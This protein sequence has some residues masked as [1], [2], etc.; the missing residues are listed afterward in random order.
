MKFNIEKEL[1][2]ELNLKVGQVQRTVD[3][4]DEGN[5]IPFIARYR[6][7]VTGSL[8]EEQL[9]ELVERLDYL[10]RLEGRKEEVINSIDK[11]DKL[12]EELEIKIRQATQLQEVEDL[13]RPYKQKR[14]T[15]ATKAKERG[16][17]PLA[18][19][20]LKQELTSGNVQ[21]LA[22][23]YVD[24]EKELESIEDVL[25]GVR[26][27]IAEYIADDPYSRKTAR[28]LT[29]EY[30]SLVSESKVEERTDY[31]IY[32]DYQEGI[33]KVRPHSTLAINRGEKEDV[34]RVKVATA[35]ENI[36]DKL[37][38]NF[39]LQE[40]IFTEEIEEAIIDGYNR[41]IAPAIEREVRN[42]LTELAEEHAI[43]V[44]AKNL[45]NLLLQPP[46]SKVRVMAIDPGFRTGS[47][48]SVLDEFGNFISYDTIYPHPPQKRWDE[49]KEKLNAL[50]K[51]YNIDIIAIGNGTASRETESLVVELIGELSQELKYIIVNEAGASVYSASKL[52]VKEFPHLDVSIRGAISI[53]RRLQDPL[54]E[55]VKIAPKHLGVGMYQHDVTESKLEESLKDVVESVVNYVGVD[56]NTASSALLEYVSGINSN[57][58]K[59]I[60]KYR[61]ENGKFKSRDEL[62]D[63]YRL[64]PKTFTQAAGFLKIREGENLL[65]RTSIHP[66]SYH[67]AEKLLRKLDFQLEDLSKK[68]ALKNLQAKIKSLD[69]DKLVEELEVGLPTLKDII[70]SLL[71]PDRDPREDLPKPIFRTD[72]LKFEDLEVGMVLQGTVR[73]VVDFGA[74]VD[75]GVKQDGLVHISQLSDKYIKNP[76]DVVAVG[77]I[78]S[79]SI[80]EV[81]AE[82]GRISLTMN[83]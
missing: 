75:I 77:D 9:R 66:E 81:D 33:K 48:I 35:D 36:I 47:K 68:E 8:N 28:K 23:K 49:A 62:K 69:L 79:V 2:K 76:L 65:D 46:L 22:K 6:K 24:L 1:A 67:I 74:F 72:V 58:A 56:L 52:A 19:L 12:T 63:V 11:Q 41:L 59:N 83:F 44:F 7:E 18:D 82:R 21:D 29:F 4:F 64:G 78:V 61:E 43:N 50:V 26:D 57:V 31:E 42:H 25:Q 73:N 60:I 5:T 39:I 40:S 55:L 15:R 10:R 70:S 71:K 13:Y 32:Y 16:L 17:E 38:Q 3:L 20:F 80:L 27:I 45:R 37:K 51:E 54:A 53:G 30:G 34:L 14:M